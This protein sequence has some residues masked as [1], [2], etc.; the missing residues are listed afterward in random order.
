MVR[1]VLL[2]ED[3]TSLVDKGVQRN[4]LMS[5]LRNAGQFEATWAEIRCAAILAR[6]VDEDVA[7]ELESAKATGAHADIRLVLPEGPPHGMTTIHASLDGARPNWTPALAAAS[8]LQ[9]AKAASSLPHYPSGMAAAAI[10]AR[11]AE[12]NYLR[13]AAARIEDALRQLPPPDVCWVGL[14]WTNGAPVQDVVDAL[15]W[16][17]I[18][19]HVQGLVF[20]GCVL[21][22]PHRNLD[23]FQI[24]IHRDW[25][26]GDDTRL[27]S[28]YDEEIA[29]LVFERT[30]AS[31]GGRATLIRA[32]IR[33]KRR[34]IVRRDGN[35]R[36]PPFNLLLDRD[37]VGAMT[38]GRA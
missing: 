16:S 19:R 25:R 36:I 8:R 5:K 10:V 11:G 12:S 7:I 29:R 24:A 27:I 20:V 9:A 3:V 30:E 4:K 35:E 22:F 18:P 6:T 37:P 23:C 14:Y 2:A 26:R 32:T 34:Q 31:A 28:D 38:A 33:G 21:A 1:C 17:Q 13:R 15:D